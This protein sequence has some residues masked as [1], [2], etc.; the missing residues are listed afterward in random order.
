V[1]TT[2]GTGIASRD[3]TPEA[4]RAVLDREIPGLAECMRAQ[5]TQFTRR[6]LLSR[7]VVGTRGSTLIVNLPGSP[8]GAG[9]SLAII[10]DLLLHVV[11]LLEGRTDHGSSGETTPQVRTS[12]H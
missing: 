8:K 6:A 7:G 11:D 3:V 5:G 2:G 4:T 12:Q 9:E 10:S 1:F